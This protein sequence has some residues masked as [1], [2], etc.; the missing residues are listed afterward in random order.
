MVKHQ[1]KH[2]Y[3]KKRG[4][5]KQ[6]PVFR[7][8]AD[9]VLAQGVG[10]VPR[11]A[12]GITKRTSIPRSITPLAWNAHSSVHAGLPRAVGPY[13]VVRT[14]TLIATRSPLMVFGTFAVNGAESTTNPGTLV[15]G[16]SVGGSKL[17]TNICAVGAS[18]GITEGGFNGS[19]IGTE[20]VSQ[21]HSIPIPGTEAN[22]VYAHN[23]QAGET[24][25]F[26]A[27]YASTTA[28]PS[29]ISVQVINP[30]PM[31]AAG[32]IATAAVC[33]VR[34]DLMNSDKAWGTVGSELISYY[35]PRVLSGGKLAL[36]GVQMDS[37]PLSMT[38]VSDF[39]ELWKTDPLICA[40]SN[41]SWSGSTRLQDIENA[42]A[43][44]SVQKSFRTGFQP[45][46]WAPIVYYSPSAANTP[47]EERGEMTFLVTME[48]RVRFDISNPACSSHQ[49]HKPSTDNEWHNMIKKASDA[50]PGVID[51]VDK[52]ADAGMR[53]GAK[54]AAYG[55]A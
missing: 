14:T 36:R 12:F 46:G 24:P 18:G 17:W 2:S 30:N 34:L 53:I 51:I 47:P 48:W 40:P 21:I 25:E 29:A 31:Q 39:R 37:M 1:K 44:S 52:V 35:K 50:L 20:S 27:R 26:E 33:P 22:G 10:S 23:V 15:L 11:R 13:S 28:V 41:I 38:D 5:V 7:S 6:K 9:R 49:M 19:A 32:G 4:T 55:G 54:Y 45:E 43:L 8:R 3:T 16:N 42:P